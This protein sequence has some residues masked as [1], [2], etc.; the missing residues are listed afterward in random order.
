MNEQTNHEEI[1]IEQLPPRSCGL[2]GKTYLPKV[3]WQK[4]CSP[5][6]GNRARF[7]TWLTRKVAMGKAR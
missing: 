2:C 1:R 5:K 3:D 7:D 6:C 4:Y